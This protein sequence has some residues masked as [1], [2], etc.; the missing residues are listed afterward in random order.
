MGRG[1]GTDLMCGL[2]AL[3]KK[4]PESTGAFAHTRAEAEGSTSICEPE[5]R[6]SPNAGSKDTFI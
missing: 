4:L 3:E 6:L 1:W 2:V 5:S